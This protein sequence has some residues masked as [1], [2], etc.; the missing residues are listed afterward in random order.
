MNF[1]DPRL[2]AYADAHTSPEPEIL[3]QLTRDTQANVLLPRMLSG[4]VQGRFLSLISHLLRPERIL[5]IGTYTGYS[6]ICLCEGLAPGGQLVT[7]DKND[8]LEVR[9][10]GWF[11]RAG[12]TDQID[13]RLGD[14]LDVLPTLTGPFDLVFLD[15]DKRN[16]LRYYELVLD[17]LRP[18]GFLLADNVL[19]SGKVTAPVA[20]SDKD[21]PAL[22]QFNE[23]V[24]NDPRVENVLLPLRDGLML[25]RKKAP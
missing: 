25:V 15:A 21:T 7:I 6:A 11:E 23:R 4:H 2:A 8:E 10:R 13:Y 24:Q 1:I 12:L 16:Y 3:Q 14:A 5:E 9:V 19:W 17:K 20:T 22:L 18:G